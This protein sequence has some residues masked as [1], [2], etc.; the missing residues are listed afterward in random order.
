[1]DIHLYLEN[2]IFFFFKF[3]FKL[4]TR[5]VQRLGEKI[6]CLKLFLQSHICL[7][8]TFFFTKLVTCDR[9]E[10]QVF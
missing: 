5:Y 8:K 3:K 10:P 4:F 7:I 6:V 9:V 1:M 2:M